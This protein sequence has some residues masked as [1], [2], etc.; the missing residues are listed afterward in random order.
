MVKSIAQVR[1]PSEASSS[2]NYDGVGGGSSG[3]GSR[4]AKDQALLDPLE[5]IREDLRAAK[6]FKVRGKKGAKRVSR[7]L[8]SPG[9]EGWS[10]TPRNPTLTPTA[11]LPFVSQGAR[12]K[13]LTPEL[14]E[15]SNNSAMAFINGD[16]S[17]AFELAS[18]MIRIDA[19][20][21]QA[22]SCLAG[23][24]ESREDV[25]KELGCRLMHAQLSK[26]G[27]IWN[28]VRERAQ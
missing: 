7:D 18:E 21:P 22:W 20:I 11:P 24:H 8:Q 17:T 12:F 13:K 19:E 23:V 28:E 1:G 5:S 4:T 15:L 16:M 10:I 3:A 2:N 26:D 6:G 25:Q 27:M 9:L 14:Q